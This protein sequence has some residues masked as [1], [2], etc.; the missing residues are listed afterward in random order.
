[1]IEIWD[2][3]GTGFGDMWAA[4][5]FLMH[6][7]A[8]AKSVIY[9]S[10][11]AGKTDMQ[12]RL[13]EMQALFSSHPLAQVVV[14]DEKPN[15]SMWQNC[16]AGRRWPSHI[17]WSPPS[18]Q[19][20]RIVCQFN[21]R[22]SADKKN[23][24]AADIEIFNQWG[25]DHGVAIVPLGLP[26]NMLECAV[27]METADIFVGCCSGMA[28]LGHSVGIPIHIVEY[29]HGAQWWHGQNPVTIHKNIET[30]MRDLS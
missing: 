4:L 22:S 8:E 23:P 25:K 20:N 27:L 1:V 18:Q 15:T 6:K 26:L 24:P 7:S 2:T 19:R 28:H 30:F 29:E 13:A 16:W 9:M 11:W 14:V 12:P 5:S 3:P 21:G 17:R 10:R